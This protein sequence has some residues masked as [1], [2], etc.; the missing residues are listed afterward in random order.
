ML[1]ANLIGG[2]VVFVV[3]LITT[4]MAWKLPYTM[5]SSP[6]PGFLPFWLGIVLMVCAAFVVAADVR[7]REKDRGKRFFAPETLKC[8]RCSS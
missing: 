6:G 5:E 7:N 1:Y 4:L 8:L 3:G 2:A